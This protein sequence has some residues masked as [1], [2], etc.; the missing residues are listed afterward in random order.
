MPRARA[1]AERREKDKE[2]RRRA[3]QALYTRP[4]GEGECRR[5]V[6]TGPLT[7]ARRHGQQNLQS[8]FDRRLLPSEEK[9]FSVPALC[10]SANTSTTLDE[11]TTLQD[12]PQR[13]VQDGEEDTLEITGA[14][15]DEPEENVSKDVIFTLVY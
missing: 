9:E 13:D 4:L 6:L 14:E 12:G 5:T 2:K 10:E 1:S 3:R 7:T 15:F 11:P 8:L